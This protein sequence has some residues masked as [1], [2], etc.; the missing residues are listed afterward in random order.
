MSTLEGVDDK[1]IATRKRKHFAFRWVP[2]A[3]HRMFPPPVNQARVTTSPAIA[4]CT[5]T[6]SLD[7]A[8]AAEDLVG[9]PVAEA[10]AADFVP[11]VPDVELVELVVLWMIPLL[12]TFALRA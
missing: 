7:E 8:Q 12:L 4:S 10:A 5:V 9:L 3:L 2:L 11:D 6:E 1:V